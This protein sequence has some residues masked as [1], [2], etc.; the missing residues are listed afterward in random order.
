[1]GKKTRQ[2]SFN[3]RFN[4]IERDIEQYNNLRLQLVTAIVDSQI[5]K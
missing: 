2:D 5:N 3:L 1:M 4:T